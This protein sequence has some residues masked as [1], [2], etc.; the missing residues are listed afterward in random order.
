MEIKYKMVD[1]KAYCEN[2][3][4]KELDEKMDPCCECLEY[5]A[6]ENSEVPVNFVDSRNNH[7]T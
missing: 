5:G 6:N 3:K 7:V 4:Y 2:C 1:F